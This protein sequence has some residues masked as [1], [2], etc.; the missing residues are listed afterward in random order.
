MGRPK[1]DIPDEERYE[2]HKARMREYKKKRV[3][4]DPDYAQKCREYNQQY[5]K[6]MMEASKNKNDIKE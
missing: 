4:N 5:F 1:L 2:R 6:K 3:A